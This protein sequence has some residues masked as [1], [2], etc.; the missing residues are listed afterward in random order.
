MRVRV[1]PTFI[2]DDANADRLSAYVQRS[3]SAP[4]TEESFFQYLAFMWLLVKAEQRLA[5]FW[6]YGT[7]LPN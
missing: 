7:S 1:L 2:V 5:N 4:I 3:W 6:K